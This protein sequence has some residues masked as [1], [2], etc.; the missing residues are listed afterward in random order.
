MF[1]SKAA[2]AE[3]LEKVSVPALVVMGSKDPDFKD[4]ESE[5]KWIAE[6]VKGE[7]RMVEGAGHYPMTEMPEIT[8]PLVAQFIETLSIEAAH[9]PAGR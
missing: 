8:G 4:P 3:R 7:Y 9:G 2:S 6:Q 5:A 1:E